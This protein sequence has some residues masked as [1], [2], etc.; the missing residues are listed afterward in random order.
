MTEIAA[1]SN[2]AIGSLYRFFPTK[3]VLADALL[4]RYWEQLGRRSA[5]GQRAV[6]AVVELIRTPSPCPSG[7][8]RRTASRTDLSAREAA[9]S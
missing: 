1:R 5:R 4:D 8:S 9:L 3:E 6:S 2:T 7:S